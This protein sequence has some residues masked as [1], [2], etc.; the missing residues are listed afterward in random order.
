[1]EAVYQKARCSWVSEKICLR[2]YFS[3]FSAA[4]PTISSCKNIGSNKDKVDGTNNNIMKLMDVSFSKDEMKILLETCRFVY[5][6]N[7]TFLPLCL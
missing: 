5:T 7:E 1:M 2:D 6:C 3:A 4:L